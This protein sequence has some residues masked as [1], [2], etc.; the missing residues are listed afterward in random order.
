MNPE[1]QQFV[2]QEKQENN[3]IDTQEIQALDSLLYNNTKELSEEAKNILTPTISNAMV[4]QIQD[5]LRSDDGK[6]INE[7]TQQRYINI[8]NTLYNINKNINIKNTI[9]DT[10]NTVNETKISNS[11]ATSLVDQ[12][13]DSS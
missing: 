7:N 9:D 2:D 11:L 5:F 4:N 12:M 13:K 1:L 10:K 6:K 3:G 8:L